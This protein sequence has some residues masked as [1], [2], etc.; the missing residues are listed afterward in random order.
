MVPARIRAAFARPEDPSGTTVPMGW[1]AHQP[2]DLVPILPPRLPRFKEGDRVPNA[3][4]WELIERLA[5]GGFGEVWKARSDTMRNTFRV[6]K[7]YLDPVSQR[8]IFENELEN[9]ELLQNELADHPNIV[10]LLEAHLEGDTPWLHYEFIPGGDLGQMVATWGNDIALRAPMAIEKLLVLADTLAHCHEGFDLDQ[11]R[12]RVIHRDMKPDNVL[13]GRTGTLKITDFGISNTQARQALDEARFATVSNMTA[14]TP[15]MLRWASTPLYASEQQIK[16]ESPHPAD[17]VHALG[18][19]LYQMVLGDVHRPLNRDYIAVLERK[20]VCRALISLI[21]QSVSSDR[22]D[23]FQHAGELAEALRR[24]PKQLI[25]PVDPQKI[26]YAQFDEKA[27]EAKTKNATA[28]QL[29]DKR[30]WAEA[31]TALESIFHP[32]LRDEDLYSRALAHRDGKRFVN[33]LG[34]EFV[35]VPKGSFWMGGSNGKPG[36]QQVNIDQDFYI[37]VYPVT[38]EEWHKVMG[39]N[40]SRFQKGRHGAEEVTGISDAD[41]R[42]FPVESVSWNDC[43]EFVRKVNEKCGESGWMYRLPREAEWEYACR[44]GA[45]TKEGCAWSYYFQTPTN[46]ISPQQANYADSNLGRPTKVGLY[47][48]NTLGIHDMHGNVWDWC[49]DIY[50]GSTR[51]IRG[52]SWDYRSCQAAI[53]GSSDPGLSN[54]FLG[55]RLAR[56]AVR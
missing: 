39:N 40:P 23:R 38:Q 8:G 52:G 24:L 15:T 31:V 30:Q 45:T 18:V 48:P 29:L 16:G 6:F 32:A 10:K 19:M 5:I 14:S 56:V 28:R 1:S 12:K 47:L 3:P 20:H 27:T 2:E 25:V 42:R 4:K 54:H 34:M 36:D 33:S 7:F 26:L 53:R 21:S 17:D 11:R 35:I 43:Q 22:E 44:G 51:V 41:L 13:V 37:G 46:T 50:S 49:E 55:L 9:I